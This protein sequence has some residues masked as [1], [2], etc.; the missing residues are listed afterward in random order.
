MLLLSIVEVI[1]LEIKIDIGMYKI[2]DVVLLVYIFDLFLVIDF[3][4]VLIE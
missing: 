2:G 3:W 4:L 1:N